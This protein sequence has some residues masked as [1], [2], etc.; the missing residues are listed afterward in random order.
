MELPVQ[1]QE[2]AAQLA[3]AVQSPVV[4]VASV[5]A[6]LITLALGYGRPSPKRVA[7]TVVAHQ[8]AAASNVPVMADVR[9]SVRSVAL[10]ENGG[11]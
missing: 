3:V 6:L 1:L 9:R 4:I 7:R 10:F 11:M 5:C 8:H 2:L